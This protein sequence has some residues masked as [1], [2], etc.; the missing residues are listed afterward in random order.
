MKR[1]IFTKYLYK[2]A[3]LFGIDRAIAY[4]IIGKGFQVLAGPI[5]IILIAK[6][7]SPEEQGF[8]YTFASVVSL[9]IFFELGLSFVILQFASHEKAELIWIGRRTLD[10]N[11]LAKQRLS[12]L[13]KLTIKWY[14][15][16]AVL[17]ILILLPAGI[18][19]L[20]TGRIT[21]DLSWKIP[22]IIMIV[23]SSGML[24][25]SPLLSLIE[26]CGLIAEIAK[27]K[28]YQNLIGNLGLWIGLSLEAKLFSASIPNII[29]IILIGSWI[30]RKFK[31]LFTDLL[32][33]SGA[34][35]N[36]KENTKISWRREIFP[37]QWKIALS[38]L[39]G[40]FIFILFTPVLFTFHGNEP[41][42]KYCYYGFVNILDI[43]KILSLWEFDCTKKLYKT[44]SDFFPITMEIYKRSYPDK[45]IIFGINFFAQRNKPSNRQ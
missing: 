5:T 4:T 45:H 6:F 2:I 40:Y 34:H 17:M 23:S 12:S 22:W 28:I 7:L 31:H 41:K 29:G 32:N 27:M 15:I 36:S 38:W 39:S 1:E 25:L 42:R 33:Y 44:R 21:S 37:L 30:Y 8:Y 3:N 16:I 14:G 11:P 26:G 19:F 18:I 10:G 9:Q 13:V 20:S 43:N 35:L 24:F